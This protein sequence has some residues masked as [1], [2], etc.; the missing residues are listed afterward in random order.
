MYNNANEN[1]EN[2]ARLREKLGLCAK[3]AVETAIL[4]RFPLPFLYFVCG[5]R[6]E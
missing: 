3:K 5:W 6:R 2:K 1:I 4:A